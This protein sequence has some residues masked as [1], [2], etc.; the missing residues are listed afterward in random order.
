MFSSVSSEISISVFVSLFFFRYTFS[1]SARIVV[2]DPWTELREVVSEFGN[3]MTEL[4]SEISE[5]IVGHS[6]VSLFVP[7]CVLL[8]VPLSVPLSFPL[9]LG[10]GTVWVPKKKIR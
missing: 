9:T 5:S 8:C 4:R 7:L 1:S 3:S 2:G 10:A 6:S